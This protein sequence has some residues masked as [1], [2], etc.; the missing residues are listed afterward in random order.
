MG[1][2]DKLSSIAVTMRK[3]TAKMMEECY[4]RLEKHVE[5]TSFPFWII[6]KFRPLKVNGLTIKDFGSPAL[7]T[8]EAGSIIYEL[9]KRDGSIATFFLVHN[10]IGMA[11][12]DKLGDEE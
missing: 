6:D 1:L 4:D 5:E 12:I 3:S 9:A 2:D 7:T 10:A 8:V 11:V